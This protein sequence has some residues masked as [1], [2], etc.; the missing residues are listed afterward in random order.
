MAAVGLVLAVGA[1][2]IILG[3]LMK[4]RWAPSDA[5]VVT[6]TPSE[7]HAAILIEPGVLQ[8]YEGTPTISATAETGDVSWVLGREED[9]NAWLQGVSVARVNGFDT[10][11]LEK[12]TLTQA[13]PMANVEPPS[14][15]V[16]A[17]IWAQSWTG[18]GTVEVQPPSPTGRWV[19]VA[20]TNG[21]VP[22]PTA[23]SVSWPADTD[24]PEAAP[25]VVFGGSL[26][27]LGGIGAAYLVW[28]RNRITHVGA[29]TNTG[30]HRRYED[31]L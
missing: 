21:A 11:D 9:A 20:M 16:D 10:S 19:L 30:R 23:I 24:V 17:D 6:A 25:M 7:P 14:R 22:G 29:G 2:L 31:Q 3:V 12:F 26:V 15:A 13:E 1:C 8:G 4:T 18:T 28:S 5:T 27:A